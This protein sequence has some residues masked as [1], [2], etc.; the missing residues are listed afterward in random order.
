MVYINKCIMVYINKCFMVYINKC[1]MVY[2]N[3]CFMVYINKC[4]MVY[5]LMLNFLKDI[6]T[7]WTKSSKGHWKEWVQRYSVCESEYE[8]KTQCWKGNQVFMY[9]RKVPLLRALN[10]KTTCF[11]AKTAHFCHGNS[12]YKKRDKKWFAGEDEFVG[13]RETCRTYL[14]IVISTACK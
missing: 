6:N 5:K 7:S 8:R 3:K 11:H 9:Y 10:I 14:F 4:F 12:W 13:S 2:I 1:V